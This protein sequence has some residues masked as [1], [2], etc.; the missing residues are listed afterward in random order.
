[1]YRLTCQP[2]TCQAWLDLSSSVTTQ[3]LT[4]QTQHLLPSKAG[5]LHVKLICFASTEHFLTVLCVIIYHSRELWVNNAAFNHC[6]H[7]KIGHR[8]F[9]VTSNQKFGNTTRACAIRF[10]M[11][12]LCLLV[13]CQYTLSSVSLLIFSIELLSPT[14]L[15]TSLAQKSSRALLWGQPQYLMQCWAYCKPLEH[16]HSKNNNFEQL[17]QS[18]DCIKFG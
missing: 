8:T 12:P 2:W 3:L 18:Q 15:K 16:Y 4:S 17:P 6:P 1:M 14:W 7:V 11:W 10:G 13:H 9:K 5:L